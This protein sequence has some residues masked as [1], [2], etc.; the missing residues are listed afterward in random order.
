MPLFEYKCS[1]CDTV[2]EKIMPVDK[3]DINC[4]KCGCIAVRI[5]SSH[6]KTASAWEVEKVKV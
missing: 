3:K 5:V 6:A 4:P 2:S 1:V